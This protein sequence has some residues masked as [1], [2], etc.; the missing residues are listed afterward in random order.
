MSSKGYIQVHSYTSTAQIPLQN[1]SIAVTDA[2]G[3]VIAFRL[4]NRNGTLDTPIE[5]E[6]P[7]LVYS[8]SPNSGVI[9][10]TRVN[11]YA[12]TEGYEL[13]E[14]KNLQVFAGTVTD[15]GL[16]MIPLSE[17]PDSFLASEI[18]DTTPQ[19]L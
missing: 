6:V 5:I 15:Q 3:S 9:P 7:D 18:F 16:A 11:L 2:S 4:T 17:Y 19:N 13:I 1:V 12:R 8:Q 10:Y 14:N